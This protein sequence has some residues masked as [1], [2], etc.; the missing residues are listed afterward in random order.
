MQTV[1][2]LLAF[3]ILGMVISSQYQAVKQ[4]PPKMD[5]QKKIEE[6]Q[7]LKARELSVAQELSQRHS[8]ELEQREKWVK[9]SGDNRSKILFEELKNYRMLAGFETVEGEGVVLEIADAVAQ[10]NQDINYYVVHDKDLVRVVNDLK[11]AGAQAI[12]ING[13]RI[14]STSELICTGPNVQI[15]RNRYPAPYT[16]KAIGPKDLMYH[17]INESELINELRKLKFGIKLQR[18][19]QVQIQGYDGDI[20]RVIQGLEDLVQ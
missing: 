7:E 2:Y 14:L 8:F 15:N 12:S 4:E 13:E 1:L 17:M 20:T 9:A 11:K 10:K 18:S 5:I 19:T 16:I 3:I 6:M